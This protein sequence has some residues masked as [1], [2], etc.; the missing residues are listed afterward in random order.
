MRSPFRPVLLVFAL[1]SSLPS[2][3]GSLQVAVAANFTA[4]F[5]AL[6]P[7][8]EQTTGHQAV[9]AFAATGQLYAQIRH[10]AP[11]E[12]LLSADSS[13]PRRLIEEGEGVAE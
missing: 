2:W 9:G 8:F 12:V 1:S 11:F 3:A 13:T 7:L 10:G 5:Q 6:A 4:P